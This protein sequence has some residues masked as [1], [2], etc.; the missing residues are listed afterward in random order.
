MN[1]AFL[2]GLLKEKSE[3]SS[4]EGISDLRVFDVLF[5]LYRVSEGEIRLELDDPV[6]PASETD[7][8]AVESLEV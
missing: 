6:T 1:P 4:V 5:V 2:V 7:L 3:R 8:E